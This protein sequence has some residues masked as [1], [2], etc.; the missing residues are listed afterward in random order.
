MKIYLLKVENKK[1]KINLK[2]D[3]FKNNVILKIY[4]FII[5][6]DIALNQ[7]RR[8]GISFKRLKIIFWRY[9]KKLKLEFLWIIIIFYEYN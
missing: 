7:Y 2:K 3:S 4:K 1:D 5:K 6:S 9:I 8:L